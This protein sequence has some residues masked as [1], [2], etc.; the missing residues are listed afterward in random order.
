MNVIH[1][2]FHV[3]K[4][5]LKEFRSRGKEIAFLRIEGA[6]DSDRAQA[7]Q[8]AYDFLGRVYDI[9]TLFT[10]AIYILS[11]KRIWIGPTGRDA[12]R[13][14][15]CSELVGWCYQKFFPK[16]WKLTP[17]DIVRNRDT[18]FIDEKDI[19]PGDIGVEHTFFNPLGHPLSILSVLI[20]VFTRSHWNHSFILV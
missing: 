8:Q 13:V 5:S 16:P 20:R 19:Q 3:T 6:T 1:T 15:V 14:V 7:L 17:D 11:G 4:E 10:Q 9:P 18:N 12:E 2:K